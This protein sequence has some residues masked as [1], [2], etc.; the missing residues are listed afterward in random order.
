LPK[1]RRQVKN[2]KL[3]NAKGYILPFVFTTI[4]GTICE[5]LYER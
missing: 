5:L 4:G 2:N 3:L 1:K